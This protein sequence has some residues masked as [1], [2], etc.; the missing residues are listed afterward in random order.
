MYRSNFI[1]CISLCAY[2]YL[3]TIWNKFATHKTL[4]PRTVSFI[5]ED[6]INYFFLFF[7]A[8]IF[9]ISDVVK[10]GKGR[11]CN[12]TKSSNSATPLKFPG[13]YEVESNL[14]A[15]KEGIMSIF[16]IYVIVIS[17]LKIV[18]G[19]WLVWSH[20]R[21]SGICSNLHSFRLNKRRTLCQSDTFTLTATH[22]LTS[23]QE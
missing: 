12:I 14:K 10:S 15:I 5:T 1:F 22:N 17:P 20:N 21:L 19:F 11:P 9:W 6:D 13:F 8:P 4:K 2:F 23:K 7:S 16:L 3:A 18:I